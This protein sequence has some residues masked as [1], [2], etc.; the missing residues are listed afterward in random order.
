MQM[1]V[2]NFRNNY[3]APHRAPPHE[4]EPGDEGPLLPGLPRVLAIAPRSEAQWV[5]GSGEGSASS[6]F[7]AEVMTCPAF[8][9]G[10]ESSAAKTICRLR[11]HELCQVCIDN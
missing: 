2:A 6:A 7:V 11:G 5:S 8:V 3:P 9:A 4:N 10:V 1:Q